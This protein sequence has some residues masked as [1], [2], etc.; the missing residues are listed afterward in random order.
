MSWL[1]LYLQQLQLSVYLFPRRV[2]LESKEN[3]LLHWSEKIFT[4]IPIQSIDYFAHDFER[5][6]IT[7]HNWY[8]ALL[9]RVKGKVWI[10]ITRSLLI[11]KD[12][13]RI[14]DKYSMIYCK[15]I[16][17]RNYCYPWIEI[18]IY[19]LVLVHNIKACHSRCTL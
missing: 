17:K 15:V 10:N 19:S 8:E 4:L 3:S 12:R 13:K 2:A 9:R 7:K 6:P 5:D 16:L 11:C 14:R 18:S 1:V